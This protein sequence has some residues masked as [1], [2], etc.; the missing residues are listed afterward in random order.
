MKEWVD[1]SERVGE[2]EGEAVGAG[3]RD[4]VIGTKVFFGEFFEG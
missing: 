1:R 4:D 2:S 3:L